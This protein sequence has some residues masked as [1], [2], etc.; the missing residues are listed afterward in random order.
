MTSPIKPATSLPW[1]NGFAI[2]RA[3]IYQDD[4]TGLD[5]TCK[6]ARADTFQDADYIVHACNAY[7]ELV[8]ALRRFADRS[9][10]DVNHFGRADDAGVLL[11][12]LGEG[13]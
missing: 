6:H 7:P 1:I 3:N 11:R 5:N 9:D 12:E 4:G 10:E 8:A 13:A 2:D